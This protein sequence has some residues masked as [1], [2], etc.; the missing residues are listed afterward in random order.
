MALSPPPASAMT[1][2]LPSDSMIS[3][4]PR[5]KIGWSSTIT[6]RVLSFISSYRNGC[7]QPRSTAGRGLNVEL[8]PKQPHAFGEAEQS[9]AGSTHQFC[10]TAAII[11]NRKADGARFAFQFEDGFGGVGV[12]QHVIDAFLRH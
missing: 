10:E 8:A 3:F 2:Y 12:L 9:V 5:R 1:A 11:E 6:M 7:G 4:S